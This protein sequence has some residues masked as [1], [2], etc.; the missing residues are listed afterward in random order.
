MRLDGYE[1]ILGLDLSKRTFKACILSRDRNFEDRKIIPGSMSPEGRRQFIST[2]GKTDIVAME[3]GTSSSN[4][5]R[6]IE[7][8]GVKVLLLNPGKLHIIYQ[9]QVKTDRQDAVK[10][11]RYVRDTAEESIVRIPVPSQ[12]ESNIREVMNSYD[13][14]KKQRTMLVN[15]LHSIFNMNGIPTV[16]RSDLSDNRSRIDAISAHLDGLPFEDACMVESMIT[17][18][19]NHIE[20]YREMMRRHILENPETA[21]PWLSL[22]GIGLI[23]AA[24]LLAYAGDCSRFYSPGQLRNYVGLV[25]RIDQSGDHSYIGGISSY[26]CK[27]IRKNIVQA[28]WSFEHRSND[29][30]LKREWDALAARNKRKQ[31]IAIHMA[32]KLLS[33]GWTLQKKRELYNGFVDHSY[34]IRK[35][36][37]EK[38]EAID[39]SSFPELG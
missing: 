8:S 17:V 35:L 20:G 19:E 28:G 25:P 14:A 18:T 22:P 6:E 15:K 4:F 33:I 38:L 26:G 36:R 3:G 11:A 23:T 37:Q 39:T 21:L 7:A 31:T 1:R 16:K 5:A 24:S 13:F 29:C 34:L 27:T 12:E 9:S 10:I 2:L 30:P 32:N